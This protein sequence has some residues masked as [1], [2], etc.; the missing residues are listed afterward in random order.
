MSM[1]NPVA[2]VPTVYLVVGAGV[3]IWLIGQTLG[4]RRLP[5]D[6]PPVFSRL[7]SWLGLIVFALGVLAGFKGPVT[8]GSFK[9]ETFPFLKQAGKAAEEA[10]IYSRSNLVVT[11]GAAVGW[12]GASK[13]AL[14]YSVYNTGTR[15]VARLTLR[16]STTSGGSLDRS[17]RGPFPPKKTVSVVVEVPDS[18]NRVYFSSGTAGS[19]E[20]VGARF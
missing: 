5:G 16:Y 1:S 6:R 11:R 3:V 20:I 4:G 8:I 2:G 12:H 17:L 18:V 10:L 7:L 13:N 19:G 14:K 15:Q 9:V